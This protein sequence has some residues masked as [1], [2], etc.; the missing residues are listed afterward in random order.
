[1]D[2]NPRK[3]NRR[4]LMIGALVAASGIALFA[5]IAFAVVDVYRIFLEGQDALELVLEHT[6]VPEVSQVVKEV[7]QETLP[8]GQEVH[9]EI[10]MVGIVISPR[11]VQLNHAGGSQQL[12]VQGYYSDGRVDELEK[13]PG[14]SLSYIS[15]DS[16][17]AQ[18]DSDGVV[19]S[20]K[21]GGVDITVSYGSYGSYAATVPVLVWGQVRR[22][23]PADPDRLLEVS[24]GESVIVLNRIMVELKPNSSADDAQL[25]ASSI[26]GEIVFGFRTFPGYLIEFE[27][28]TEE[29]LKGALDTLRDD[30]RIAEAYPDMLVEAS[31]HGK[32]ET[33]NLPNDKRQAYLD[34]GMDK[35]WKVMNS[36]P[37]DLLDPVLIAMIDTDFVLVPEPDPDDLTKTMLNLEFDPNR[38]MGRNPVADGAH[39]IKVAGVMIA[40]NNLPVDVTNS[41]IPLTC[42]DC[43]FSGVVTSVDGLDYLLLVYADGA[44]IVY[45]IKA[46]AD[47]KENFLTQSQVASFLEDLARYTPVDV[48]NMSVTQ[49]CGGIGLEIC[50]LWGLIFHRL[51]SGMPNVTFVVAAGNDGRDAKNYMPANLAGPGSMLGPSFLP[52]LP[53]VI[54]VGATDDGKRASFHEPP[55]IL[56]DAR[57]SNYGD[58][59]TLGAPGVNVWTVDLDPIFGS[60]YNSACGTSFAAPL[61]TGTV[62]LMKAINPN[63]SPEYIRNILVGTGG[64]HPVCNQDMSEGARCPQ[65]HQDV[66]PILDAG[67]AVETVIDDS[68]NAEIL[69]RE[70]SVEGT[71]LLD[72]IVPVKNTGSLAWEFRLD[73]VGSSP[74]DKIIDSAIFTV[75]PDTIQPFK[76]GF[77]R[78]PPGELYELRLYRWADSTSLVDS[79]LLLI[80]LS[81][82]P[83]TP[84]PTPTP[85]EVT[86][87]PS[88]STRK[89]WV[90]EKFWKRAELSMVLAELDCGAAIN[91]RDE[92]G[93]TV[94]HLAAKDNKHPEVIRTLIEAGANISAVNAAHYTALHHAA[95][96]NANP[97]VIRTLLEAGADYR[98]TYTDEYGTPLHIALIYHNVTGVHALLDYIEKQD[99]HVLGL[100]DGEGCSSVLNSWLKGYFWRGGYLHKALGGRVK[101]TVD[102]VQ[103]GLDCG[104]GVHDRDS[105]GRTPLHWAVIVNEDPEV[106]R[107][108]LEAG[109][110]VD[111]EDARGRTPLHW[112]VKWQQNPAVIEILLTHGAN[113]NARN[114]WEVTPLHFAV[115]R[116]ENPRVIQLL[117]DAG[118]DVDART[119]GGQTPLHW[120][121][122]DNDTLEVIEIL[123]RNN[124]DPHWKTTMGQT[125][126]YWAAQD[127]DN[128][129]VIRALLDKG[130]EV[131]ARDTEDA[132]PLRR[133]VQYN[134][135]ADI[136]R[137]LLDG[138]ADVDAVDPAARTPLMAAAWFNEN[139][140]VIQALLD[141]GAEVNAVDHAG[142]PPLV[143]AAWNNPNPAVIETL[144]DWGAEIDAKDGAGR[145]PLHAAVQGNDNPAVMLAL[146]Q[147]G[148][149]AS[150]RNSDGETPLDLARR[151]GK[152]AFIEALDE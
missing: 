122:R 128:P 124:A 118:S 138:G 18:V 120:A 13:F 28:H 43:S 67:A 133:A 80:R 93:A 66:W 17:V 33:L 87:C 53:N 115:R 58:A 50:P 143:A 135:N 97:G 113:P 3:A 38:I 21:A 51:M 71:D 90:S 111:I 123:L 82:A 2:E 61:V 100:T 125:P 62:A 37:T 99:E 16:S 19:T 8:V 41:R 10:Q 91:E 131:N 56:P 29:E 6:R 119:E 64:S 15:S 26:G 106:V 32:I 31:Q 68:V 114:N 47:I 1:M 73:A 45:P 86:L 98:A 35:A 22:I 121:A 126:M 25:V 134:E 88:G 20:V 57:G 95:A 151:L 77:H 40:Q 49:S 146:L 69:S 147:R 139:P 54:T 110:F 34:A 83:I 12:S 48:V 96:H 136:I 102:A 7:S 107:A 14:V 152:A 142:E 94:L 116:N 140:Y 76:L 36:V 52:A 23:P 65:E 84:S 101:T 78:P 24:D 39:G 148:A 44:S 108:L 132:T 30:Q 27:A 92:S 145:T 42:R 150:E 89:G 112:A 103:A 104:V 109:A 74:A 46:L 141:G 149:D 105:G 63:L 4:K 55:C 137:A 75:S 60:G 85:R 130:A 70:I 129:Q 79:K 144:L 5:G 9:Q 117:I 11:I 72:I 59:V 81:F 127:T